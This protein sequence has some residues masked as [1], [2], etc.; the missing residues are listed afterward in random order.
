MQSRTTQLVIFIAAL[1]AW[2]P[3]APASVFAREVSYTGNEQVIYVRPGEPSQVQFPGTVEGGFKPR[4]ASFALEKQDRSLIVFPKPELAPEGEAM[5]VYLD[6]KRSYAL[7]L[8]P[9]SEQHPR[10]SLVT[11]LDNREPEV[12]TEEAAKVQR[13]RQPTGFAP[14]STING[15]MRE[16]VLV[17]EFGRQKGITGYRR[18]NRFSGETVLDDGALEAKIAEIFMGSDLWGYVVDVENKL[19]TTQR[20]NPA[21][22]RLD[23]TKAITVQR[24]ELAPRPLT[25]EQKIAGMHKSK[26]YIV[27]R[28][29]RR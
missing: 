19:E 18:S 20:V 17:A 2:G 3:A 27:T 21:T 25:A 10:D 11:I 28:A 8:V 24:W 12:E 15:L 22:F 16:M 4:D 13:P 9:A 6:D 14:S 29:K 5:I 1:A 26:V 23:G 7:R